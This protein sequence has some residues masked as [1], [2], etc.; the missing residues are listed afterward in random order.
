MT[1][2][3]LL[4]GLLALAFLTF[5]GLG[6]WQ[7]ERL[8]WKQ[9]LIARV[10]ARIHA[11]PAAPPS[12]ATADDEYRRI[13]LRG[14][15]ITGGDTLTQAVTTRG[16]GFWVL[17]PFKTEDGRSFLVNRGFIPQDMKDPSAYAAPASRVAIT[18][19]LRL[20]EPK[21]G[22]LR[23]NDPAAGRWF[24]RDIPEIA[25]ARGLA[26]VAPYF[27]DVEAL[28]SANAYPVGGLTV[29]AFT[30]HHLQYALTWFAMAA[31]TIIGGIIVMRR[32]E[33]VD[34]DA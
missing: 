28:G 29:V 1:K 12:S 5:V 34:R 25:K 33:R 10:D 8:Q 23:E 26:S 24:S 31:L 11:E 9:D 16:P 3:I 2:R 6:V 20:S 27:I 7:I 18:G 17:T 14:T 19:L 22:F 15:Y 4:L 13:V 30:N 21:G 32:G